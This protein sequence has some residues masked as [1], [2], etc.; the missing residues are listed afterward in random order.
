MGD[1]E[2][3]RGAK[4]GQRTAVGPR[5]H[6]GLAIAIALLA[7][8]SAAPALAAKKAQGKAATAAT[9]AA[10]SAA[11]GGSSWKLAPCNANSAADPQKHVAAMSDRLNAMAKAAANPAALHAAIGAELQATVDWGEMARLTLPTQWETLQAAQRSEFIPLL[12]KM[13]INTYVKRFQAGTEV[14]V[15]YKGVKALGDGRTQV[16]TAVTVKKTSAEVAY[17]LRKTE[18]CWRVTDIVVDEAS[19]VQSYRQNFA[20]IL[21]KEGWTGLIAR[22]T[23][24][25]NKK[26]S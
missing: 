2:R 1:S 5:G 11:P 4:M 12:S 9:P 21:T 6:R 24:A 20:K 25:A 26:V 7:L 19:Q 18:G 22:M 8:L 23:K 15:Q 3:T 14:A 13:V 17:L 16:T 10:P